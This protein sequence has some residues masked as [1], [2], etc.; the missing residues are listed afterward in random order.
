MTFTV[1]TNI[2]SDPLTISI[3]GVSYV[4]GAG[5]TVNIP[6][7]IAVEL[8]RMLASQTRE[9]IAVSPPFSD[10]DVKQMLANIQ[11]RLAIVEA[12]AA[13][14]ELPEIPVTAGTYVLHADVVEASEESQVFGYTLSWDAVEEEEEEEEE[15]IVP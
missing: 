13:T 7:E 15:E 1:P 12:A 8:S 3:N 14:K 4:L 11:T 2:T 10:A 5:E 9:S 6:T